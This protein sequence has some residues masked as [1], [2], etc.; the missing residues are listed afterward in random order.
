[1]RNQPAP[2]P[3]RGLV[4]ASVLLFVLAA[5]C[6]V[7]SLLPEDFVVD[8]WDPGGAQFAA[9]YL[10][11]LGVG[12][13]QEN[14]NARRFVCFASTPWLLLAG[15]LVLTGGFHDRLFGVALVALAGGLVGLLFG[16]RPKAARVAVSLA[17]GAVG[18]A[19]VFPLEIALARAP[20]AEASRALAEWTASDRDYARDDIGV[21]LSAPEGWV[22]L[23]S[24]SP[25][26]PADPS[27]A[28]AL[29]HGRTETRAVVRVEPDPQAGTLD[30]Y[31]DAFAE[32]WS[33]REPDLGV[34]G[35]GSVAL[36]AVKARRI[37]V[38]W[39]RDEVE[40]VGHVVAWRD[41][42]RTLALQ[43]WHA[44]SAAGA[45]EAIDR[46]QQSLS[47]SLPVS[48]RIESTAGAASAEMPQ[49]TR[50]ALEL[51]VARRPEADLPTLFRQGLA[52][53]SIGFQRLGPDQARD[54][55]EINRALYGGMPAAEAAWMEDYVRRVRAAEATTPEE[56]ARAMRAMAAA[57]RRLSEP[58]RA[59]LRA[60]LENA[61]AAAV[62]G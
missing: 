24:S 39:V 10:T 23:R 37:D 11:L 22:V 5:L 52:A 49:M 28:V 50:R 45:V 12:V 4:P 53:A 51:L 21:R 35:R 60:I 19:L 25:Y 9:F 16:R 54:M 29:Y 3:H 55:G 56:D 17:V 46:L 61:V 42:S 48:A 26:V 41:A 7:R 57:A 18:A 32:H 58:S 36:G 14:D 47:L 31:L 59:R 20:R 43:T 30:E 1:M 38:S 62:Q 34:E 2:E 40:H 6:V 13:L 27:T 8:A 44:A 33:S 15:A